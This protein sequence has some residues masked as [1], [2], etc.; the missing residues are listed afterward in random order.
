MA[1]RLAAA[2]LVI[3]GSVGRRLVFRGI[4]VCFSSGIYT[5]LHKITI[6]L[7]VECL[8]CCPFPLRAVQF[9][10]IGRSNYVVLWHD[11]FFLTY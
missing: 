7:R 1:R 2:D 6:L 8:R 10:L 5:A 3:T 11:N 9:S 4:S